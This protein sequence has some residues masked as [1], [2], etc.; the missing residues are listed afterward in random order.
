[1]RWHAEKRDESGSMRSNTTERNIWAQLGLS[2]CAVVLPPIALGAALY[3]MLTVRDEG[4]GSLPEGAAAEARVTT[5][6][7][8]LEAADAWPISADSQPVAKAAE[9][10]LAGGKPVPADDGRSSESPANPQP[11][12]G[13]KAIAQESGPV[14]GRVTVV[15]PP[16]AANWPLSP[17]VDRVPTDS[18]DTQPWPPAAAVPTP[19]LPRAPS[20][21]IQVPPPQTPAAQLP[22]SQVTSQV[23]AT[24][25]PAADQPFAEGPP[26]PTARKRV[27]PSY[28]GNLAR[29][30]G[31]R[32]DARSETH[33]VRQNAQQQP[34]PTF[35]LKDWL[36]QL[37]A[38]T[39]NTGG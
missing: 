7:P 15:V 36:Q 31:G 38:R 35:S 21:P 29:R 6:E 37:G 25:V 19:L 30:S 4:T 9:P 23:S 17:D 27:R 32:A 33:A 5:P 24:G 26:A 12:V 13:K 11:A 18:V 34:Q 14:P 16:A 10:F 20:L 1:V 8:R 22:A 2:A 3:S 28:L 39:R